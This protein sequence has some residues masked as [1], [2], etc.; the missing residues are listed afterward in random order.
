MNTIA[1]KVIRKTGEAEDI[2]SLE[3]GSATGAPLP[4]FSAGSHID[5]QIKPGLTRQYSLCNDPTESHRYL[6]AVLRDPKS[7]G[8]SIAVHDSIKEGDIIT[9][10]EPRNHFP[11]TPAKRYFLIAGGIGITPILCMAERLAQINADFTLHY[12]TRALERTA[13]HRRISNAAF[14]DKVHF[15]FDT[16]SSEQRLNLE[17]LLAAEPR[18]S[19]IY[20][21]GPAGFI[22]FV[23]TTA[24]ANGW[25]SDQVHLE[26]FGPAPLDTV[27]DT[28]FEVKI[29]STGKIYPVPV[30][31]TVVQALQEH[32]IQVPVSCEQGICGTCITRVLEGVPDHRDL[33]FTDD[34]HALNDQ[35][36]PCCSRAKSTL[37]VLDL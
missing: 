10:S 20:V 2:I 8:G 15:H 24:H 3:L 29:A 5:V 26:Y 37:L 31:R 13:F 9:I 27:G 21:C 33:Y 35:F 16:G 34:E 18:E 28:A 4:P 25:S 30:D 11:L 32:N 19:H 14:A 7:R 6:I 23:T 17:K 36:T 1:V 12:G 22:D